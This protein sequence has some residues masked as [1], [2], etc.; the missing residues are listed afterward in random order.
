M[1]AVWEGKLCLNGDAGSFHVTEHM[2]G[3]QDGGEGG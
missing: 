1:T 3:L 2:L